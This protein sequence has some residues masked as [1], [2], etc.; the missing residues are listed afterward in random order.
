MKREDEKQVRTVISAEIQTQT[1]KISG[2]E[3]SK[4]LRKILYSVFPHTILHDFSSLWLKTCIYHLVA[5]K[6]YD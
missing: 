3:I 2:L 4:Q 5:I 6:S 1:A